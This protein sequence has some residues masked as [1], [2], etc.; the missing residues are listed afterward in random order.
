LIAR[1]AGD[2]LVSGVDA[3]LGVDALKVAQPAAAMMLGMAA[4]GCRKESGQ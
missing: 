4:T 2:E 1:G 3:E